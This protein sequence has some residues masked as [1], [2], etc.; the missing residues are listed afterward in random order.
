MVEI[1]PPDN[2]FDEVSTLKGYVDSISRWIS[3]A[4]VEQGTLLSNTWFRG[5]GQVYNPPL[6]PG[7]YREKFTKRAEALGKN[8]GWK[9]LER[10]R[11]HLERSMLRE[12][13]TIGATFFDPN[14]VVNVYLTAQHFGMSTRLL[15]WTMNPL[16]ALFFAVNNEDKHNVDG[17][18]FAVEPNSILR[19]P[20]PDPK[21]EGDEVLWG[22]ETVRHAYVSDA[23][24]ESFWHNPRK[25]RPPLIVPLIPDNIPGRIGQQSSAFTLHMHKATSVTVPA[26]KLAKL[27]ILAAGDAKRKMLDELLRMKINEFTIYNDLDHLS[28]DLKRVWGV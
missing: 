5:I 6:V 28:K 9:D 1:K 11:Q 27:K 26:G 22:A 10:A 19:E 12:F 4:D 15:D 13:R 25:V 3:S 20:K 23:I 21:K 7:V 18:V 14:D 24:G 16:A 2:Y 8:H 17:E